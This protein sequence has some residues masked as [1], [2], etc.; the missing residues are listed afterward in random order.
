[1]SIRL[2]IVVESEPAAK[3]LY[4]SEHSGIDYY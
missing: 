2:S 3:A 1:M 4:R